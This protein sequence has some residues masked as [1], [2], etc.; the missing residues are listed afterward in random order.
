MSATISPVTPRTRPATGIRTRRVPLLWTGFVVASLLALD[1]LDAAVWSAVVPLAA[2]ALWLGTTGWRRSLSNIRQRAL[3]RRDLAVIAVLYLVVVGLWRLAFTVFTADRWL[4]LFLCF[5]GGMLLGVGGPVVYTV[6]LRH[7]PLRSLG[8]GLHRLPATV[9]LG[10][11]FAGV[12][13]LIMLWGYELPAPVDWV[14]LLVLSLA[15]GLFEAVFFRGF[16]QG[17]LQASFGIGPVVAGAAALYAL[18]HVGY[19]MGIG[20]LGFL[21]ALGVVYAVAYRLTEN[22]LVLWPLLT[23]L[24]GWFANLEA[25]DI[26]L[27]WASI[28]GFADVLGLMALVIW[29]AHRHGRELARGGRPWVVQ[30]GDPDD[31]PRGPA[32]GAGHLDRPQAVP[33]RTG[34]TWLGK[35]AEVVAH[36]T[37]KEAPSWHRR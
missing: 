15:V 7:R 28:A 36:G 24:G 4:G 12:Q 11:L 22:V 23:P 18:Y 35:H 14:P 17:R 10:L 1:V 37:E 3:D 13:A 16:V 6:W 32:P 19:G 34:G 5:G 30:A 29:L 26:E 27:P 33:G 9:A 21:F 8:L 2:T 31:R 25:G 20:E